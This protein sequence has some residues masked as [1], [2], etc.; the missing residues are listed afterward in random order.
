MKIIKIELAV[1]LLRT[2]LL[3]SAVSAFPELG[4]KH[5]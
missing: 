3:L 4:G 1:Q 5:K 2:I